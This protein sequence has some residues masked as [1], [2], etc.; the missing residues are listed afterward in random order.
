MQK[1]KV[2]DIFLDMHICILSEVDWHIFAMPTTVRLKLGTMVTNGC[3]A[4]MA[5]FVRGGSL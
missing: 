3:I 4:S 1:L 2:R 5:S